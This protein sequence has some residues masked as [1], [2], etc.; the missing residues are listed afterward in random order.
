[1]RILLDVRP[2]ATCA[3]GIG[4]YARMLRD[5]VQAGVDGHSCV[6]AGVERL[7]FRSPP[8]EELALPALLA[9]ERVELFHS[10]L[11]H[12]PALLG[13]C[14]AAITI[15]D[16]APVLHPELTAPG[17]ARLFEGAAE[18]AARASLVVCPSETARDD[19][20]RALSLPTDKV[21]VVPEAPASLF[22]EE[23]EELSPAAE[24]FLLVVGS[25]E[26]RKN[27]GLVLEALALDPDLPPAVFVGPE[28][29]FDLLGEAERLGVRS[30]VHRDGWLSDRELCQRYRQATALLF[31][32]RYEGFGLPLVEAFACGLPA[33]ASRTGSLPEVA[34]DAALLVDPDDAQ[35]LAEATGRLLADAE[36]R[37][38]LVARGRKRVHER[39]SL[40]AVRQG[41][42]AAWDQ[43]ARERSVAA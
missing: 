36:L 24:P 38:E 16:A 26:S 2:S 25:I 21:R 8:E 20:T 13:D 14:A 1:M 37:A 7:R 6:A 28:A 29:G 12:L 22:L 39:Y 27:P 18:A 32:S 42:A 43:V 19:V 35:E 23:P 34:G 33:V 11:F 5:T 17:F 30:R 3:T 10:P 41:L 4:R 15:H 31:P 9:R 40:T